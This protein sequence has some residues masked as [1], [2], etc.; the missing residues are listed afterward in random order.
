MK[1]QCTL[2]GSLLVKQTLSSRKSIQWNLS[3][4]CSIQ[5]KGY[6]AVCAVSQVLMQATP[7]G[8][9]LRSTVVFQQTQDGCL[10]ESDLKVS[11]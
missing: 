5:E 9:G 6:H 7:R 8:Y 10:K 11:R 2:D 3:V 4:L 1:G